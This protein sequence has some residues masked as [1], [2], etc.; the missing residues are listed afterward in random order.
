MPWGGWIS[1]LAAFSSSPPQSFPSFPIP[2]PLSFLLALLFLVSPSIPTPLTNLPLFLVPFLDKTDP[3]GL[4]N[5][6]TIAPTTHAP[7][8]TPSGHSCHAHVSPEFRPYRKS[9]EDDCSRGHAR[10]TR[11]LSGGLMTGGEC[12]TFARPDPCNNGNWTI[13]IRTC[14]FYHI[15]CKTG[16][17]F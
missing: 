9:G 14:S 2:S 17:K 3:S 4:L 1:A 6:R 10:D 11:R 15:K 16:L 5:V 8:Q 7:G 12:H 13:K